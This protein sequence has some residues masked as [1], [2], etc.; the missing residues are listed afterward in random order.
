MIVSSRLHPDV[1]RLPVEK[2]RAGYKSDVYFNR[3]RHILQSDLETRCATMQ[4]FQKRPNAVVVGIDHTLA[5]LAVG[6]GHYR[7]RSRAQSLFSRYL[8]AEADLYRLWRRLP[9]VSW[10]AYE[11]VSHLVF[12]ISLELSS[13]WESTAAQLKVRAL[14]DGEIASPREPVMHIEGAYSD[15]AHLETLYLGVLADATRVASNTRDVVDAANGKPILMFGARHQSH[16]MQASSGYAAYVSGA[17]GVSTNE[18]GEWW[19]SP[20]VGTVPHAL[21]AAY[22]GSTVL[23]SMKFDEHIN[24]GSESVGDLTAAGNATGHINLTPLVDFDN[25]VVGTSLDVAKALGKRLW[26]VRVDTSETL[27]DQSVLAEVVAAK[28]ELGAGATGVTPRL[29]NILRQKLD[30]AGHTHVRI[31]VSGGFDAAKIKRFE[32]EKVPVDIYGVG[33]SLVHGSVYDFTADIVRLEG[34]NVAKVGRGYTSS[35]RL[36]DVDWSATL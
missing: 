10:E 25:D 35:E 29:V 17:S 24:R 23:A 6:A 36:H 32:A 31:V 26:G 16:E 14:Y 2:I 28:G 34:K 18:G 9:N 1:F 8:K 30:E 21:I 19:G 20:G 7:D 4:L 5:L 27:V 33:S 3:T 15:F 11:R 22:G 13:L 12:D